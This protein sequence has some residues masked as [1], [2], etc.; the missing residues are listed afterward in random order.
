LTDEKRLREKIE[1]SGLKLRYIAEKVGLTYQGFLNK[2][3][4]K[5]DFRAK[6]IQI[7][8]SLLNISSEER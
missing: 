4:N 7:L 3:T 1:E 6:E 5:S 2:L 8:C